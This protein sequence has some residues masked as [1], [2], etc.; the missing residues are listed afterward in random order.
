MFWTNNMTAK[1]KSESIIYTFHFLSVWYCVTRKSWRSCPHSTM[2][3][4]TGSEQVR[5]SYS[6]HRVTVNRLQGTLIPGTV[7]RTLLLIIHQQME[8]H[9]TTTNHKP[10]TTT[11]KPRTTHPHSPTTGVSSLIS[12]TLL[13]STNEYNALWTDKR[14]I[15]EH[16]DDARKWSSRFAIQSLWL[17]D[18]GLSSTFIITK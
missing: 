9:M 10:Q 18:L 8:T 7:P 6:Y 15:Y 11:H 5:N 13:Y 4:V 3:F 16:A 17:C 14:S 2:N 12:Q 1:V